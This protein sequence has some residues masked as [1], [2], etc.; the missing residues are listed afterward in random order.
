MGIVKSAV[1]LA[2]ASAAAAIADAVIQKHGGRDTSTPAEAALRPAPPESRTPPP[3]AKPKFGKQLGN[4]AKAAAMSGAAFVAINSALKAKKSLGAL[5][6]SLSAAAVGFDLASKNL[7]SGKSVQKDVG[8]FGME[9]AAKVAAGGFYSATDL[10]QF[11]SLKPGAAIAGTAAAAAM[12]IQLAQR[13]EK[14]TSMLAR[15]SVSLNGFSV[16]GPIIKENFDRTAYP[17]KDEVGIPSSSRAAQGGD[18]FKDDPI[19][20]DKKKH[21]IKGVAKAMG[22]PSS[23]ARLLPKKTDLLYGFRLQPGFNVK[24]NMVFK[25]RKMQSS[26]SEPTTPA[27]P[28]SPH[29]NAIDTEAGHR[30]E[31]DNTPGAERLHVFHRS[32]TCVE[33]HPD[34]QIVIK[35]INHQNI[36]SYA[37]I[38]LV[39]M[40]TCNIAAEGDARVRAKNE[41][42]LHADG[43]MHLHTEK[44]FHVWA[45]GDIDLKAAKTFKA[46]GIELDLRYVKLPGTPVWT[47]NG[48]APRMNMTAVKE[49]HPE[50]GALIEAKDAEHRGKLAAARAKLVSEGVSNIIGDSTAITGIVPPGVGLKV[51]KTAAKNLLNTV[52]MLNLLQSGPFPLHGLAGAPAHEQLSTEGDVGGGGTDAQ[53]PPTITPPVL[54]EDQTPKQNP[55][56]NPLVYYATTPAAVAYRALLFESPEEVGDVEMYQAHKETCQALGD[57]STVEPPLEGRLTQPETGLVAPSSLPLVK[58]LNRDDY[59]GQGSFDP[60]TALGGTSFTLFDLTDSLA[61]P[62][63]ANPVVT[64]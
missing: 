59:R 30:I 39:A 11:S 64:V 54:T 17:R 22:K 13:K 27:A 34:G 48:Y 23:W 4:V 61:R 15:F 29:N 18:A 26:W 2:T 36:V 19:H 21:T 41:I 38:N 24:L 52:T 16:F 35:S 25:D 60:G 51:G 1:S 7:L 42:H 58:Y 40:G 44:N 20:K 53:A 33:I 63:V 50:V 9:G 47:T 55:L 14:L 5:T 8:V 46:D 12:A 3:P 37:D 57:I 56:G 45:G 10:V 32:G 43:D 31:I 49:D 62:D 28:Q 6:T